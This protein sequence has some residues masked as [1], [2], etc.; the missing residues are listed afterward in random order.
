MD[1]AEKNDIVKSMLSQTDTLQMENHILTKQNQAIL[2]KLHKDAQNE[3]KSIFNE[4]EQRWID[5]YIKDHNLD[6]LKFLELL[7]IE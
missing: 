4:E 2:D 6:N 7:N 1:D 5:E 3:I